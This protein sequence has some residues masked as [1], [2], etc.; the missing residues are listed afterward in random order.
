[1]NI[2]ELYCTKCGAPLSLD[3]D[4]EVAYCMYCGNKMLIDRNNVHIFRKIDEAEITRA[5]TERMRF[6]HEVEMQKKQEAIQKA[7][8]EREAL[9][10]QNKPLVTVMI[11]L[12][13]VMVLSASVE[14][15]LA[16]LA[17]GAG[18]VVA[19]KYFKN[20]FR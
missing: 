11:V 7:E 6:L 15:L 12:F 5:Q 14:P 13:I 20:L 16:V 8:E 4:Q 1:M 2:V 18:V 10:E 17:L 3:A 19:I 9:N